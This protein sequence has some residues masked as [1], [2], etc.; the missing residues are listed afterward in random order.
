MRQNEE[1]GAI[2]GQCNETSLR[3]ILNKTS[4]LR[5]IT[6]SKSLKTANILSCFEFIMYMA[7]R[8]FRINIRLKIL[9]PTVTF[10]VIYL[11]K[12]L[13]IRVNKFARTSR[14]IIST[15]LKQNRTGAPR[16]GAGKCENAQHFLKT[17]YVIILVLKQWL[18]AL[19]DA[20]FCEK[21]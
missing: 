19:T 20:W 2:N 15:A 3:G 7:T 6:H 4:L 10:R 14:H 16:I 11:T 13:Q 17:Y 5:V 21:K 18:G 12:Q 9:L 8:L 1:F